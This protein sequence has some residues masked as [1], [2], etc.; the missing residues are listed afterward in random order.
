MGNQ[1]QILIIFL[2]QDALYFGLLDF[3]KLSFAR[4]INT[5]SI[6]IN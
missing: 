5:Y 6:E 3:I 2:L 4:K 1:K